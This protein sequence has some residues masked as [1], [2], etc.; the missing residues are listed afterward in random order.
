M[1]NN[2][3]LK[4]QSIMESLWIDNLIKVNKKYEQ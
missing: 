1:F 4:V 3:T 2:F